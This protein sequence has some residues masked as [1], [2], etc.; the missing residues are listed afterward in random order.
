MRSTWRLMNGS[1]RKWF[2]SMLAESVRQFPSNTYVFRVKVAEEKKRKHR[3]KS[4]YAILASVFY[5]SCKK[6][7]LLALTKYQ[8]WVSL[9]DLS[10]FGPGS[11]HLI[12]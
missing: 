5:S 8:Y 10:S 7:K 11:F 6:E 3:I 12:Y 1:R 9:E 2:L 4:N